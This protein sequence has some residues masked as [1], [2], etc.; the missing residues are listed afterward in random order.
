MAEGTTDNMILKKNIILL[1]IFAWIWSLPVHANSYL[2][3]LTTKPIDHIDETSQIN[4]NLP[5][6]VRKNNLWYEGNTQTISPVVTSPYP[7]Y[8]AW[9]R[10][11]DRNDFYDY[12]TEELQNMIYVLETGL[13]GWG[14][15]KI[16][17][18]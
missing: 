5:I 8:E 2:E 12:T 17:H 15:Y 9:L 3:M 14:L 6:I 4:P 13:I 18:Y 16:Y 7:K 11:Q 1:S 10:Y